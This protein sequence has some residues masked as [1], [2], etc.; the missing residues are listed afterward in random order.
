MTKK[1]SFEEYVQKNERPNC[2]MCVLPERGE[3]DAVY[4]Q[5]K[6]TKRQVADYLHSVLGYES[7][8]VFGEENRI[9]GISTTVVERHYSEKHHFNV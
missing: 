2:A 3:I 9:I 8:T 6:A 4:R 5:G 1:L 7:K